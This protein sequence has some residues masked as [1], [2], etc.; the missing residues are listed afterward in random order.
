[1][2]N[3]PDAMA[4]AGGVIRFELR[5]ECNQSFEEL[6]NQMTEH[7][8]TAMLETQWV[9]VDWDLVVSSAQHSLRT[10]MMLGVLDH[11]NDA[12]LVGYQQRAFAH[13]QNVCG[14]ATRQSVRFLGEDNWTSDKYHDALS[15]EV[16]LARAHVAYGARHQGYLDELRRQELQ[17]ERFA[18]YEEDEGMAPPAYD[19]RAFCR[20]ALMR[21]DHMRAK[22]DDGTPC[23]TFVL[24]GKRGGCGIPFPDIEALVDYVWDPVNPTA[25]TLKYKLSASFRWM[26]ED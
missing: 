8:K 26:E 2:E 22:K 24:K 13:L 18:S 25:W 4:Y 6:F 16:R 17:T 9:A 19:T 21:R 20:L 5:F 14:I 3:D 15:A 7:F 12:S 11:Q 1:M 23:V 10:F